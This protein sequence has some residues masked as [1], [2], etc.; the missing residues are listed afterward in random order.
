VQVARSSPFA[1]LPKF[2]RGSFLLFLTAAIVSVMLGDQ[3]YADHLRLTPGNVLLGQDLWSPIT[4]NVVFRADGM[5]GLVGAVVV[6]WFFGSR[7]EE[8]WGP[9]KYLLLVIGAGIAGHLTSV[10]IALLSQAVAAFELGGT[11]PIDMAALAAFGFVF[12]DRPLRLMAALPLTAKWLAVILIGVGLLRPLATGAWPEAIPMVVAILVVAAV[13]TQPW[14]RL[15]DSG[16][17]GG[18]KKPKKRHLR[19][20]RPDSE[21]LN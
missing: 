8:F 18:S 12:K 3:P 17:L 4:A 1:S 16:K 7:L 6:Q 14:R 19:V 21:L 5:G 13:T 15:R 11:T 9:K 20:V 10:L 2:A